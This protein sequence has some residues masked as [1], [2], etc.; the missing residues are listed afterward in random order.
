[1][2]RN[3]KSSTMQEFAINPSDTGSPEVQCAV[4]TLRIQNLVDHLK[5]N[6][7]DFQSRRGLLAMIVRRKKLLDY[8]KNKKFDRYTILIDRLKLRK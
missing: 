6:E 5:I 3:Q 4:L 2:D 8:L 1:M 7:K